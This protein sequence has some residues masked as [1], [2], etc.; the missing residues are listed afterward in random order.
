M[1]DII[2]YNIISADKVRPRDTLAKPLHLDVAVSPF[3]NPA[4]LMRWAKKSLRS[5]KTSVM[6]V[7]PLTDVTARVAYGRFRRLCPDGASEIRYREFLTLVRAVHSE[8][9]GEQ[10]FLI[11]TPPTLPEDWSPVAYRGTTRSPGSRGSLAR[12]GTSGAAPKRGVGTGAVYATQQALLGRLAGVTPTAIS[13]P[14]DI[15]DLIRAGQ[16]ASF[17]DGKHRDFSG[18]LDRDDEGEGTTDLKLGFSFLTEEQEEL[19]V[20]ADVPVPFL[21]KSRA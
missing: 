2:T 3:G 10:D 20:P 13:T 7:T 8:A 21:V 6:H 5:S 1:A 14:E 17:L 15:G 16:N 12:A 18:F 19:V 9:V 11:L 4:T